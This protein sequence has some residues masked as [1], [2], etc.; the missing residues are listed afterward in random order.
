MYVR[1]SNEH[2]CH[3]VNLY[4]RAKSY[5]DTEQYEEAVRDYEHVFKTDKSNR[6]YR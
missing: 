6:E 1:D 5:M 4:R 2:L 3:N